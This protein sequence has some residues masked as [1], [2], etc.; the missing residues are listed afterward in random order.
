M[1][2]NRS[3]LGVL[4]GGLLAGFLDIVYA[5]IL[6]AA[7]DATPLRVLQSIAS[8]LLGSSAYQGGTAAG[9][10]GFALHLVITVVAAW[11]FW[12]AVRRSPLMQREI[13]WCGLVFGVLVYL[14]MNFV[15]LPL[16]AVPFQLKYSPGVMVQGFVSHAAL[17]G[18]PIALTFAGG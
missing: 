9:V 2:A 5:F 14:F 11:V 18:L 12:L 4:I 13:L 3:Y 8:G 10:L 15:V 16:S 7:R 1:A 6:A 17:V